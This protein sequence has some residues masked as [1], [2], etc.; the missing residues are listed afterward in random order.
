MYLDLKFDRKLKLVTNRLL[1]SNE[2]HIGSG[3]KLAPVFLKGARPTPWVF[4]SHDVRKKY[5]WFWNRVCTQEFNLIPSHCRF[6][7]WKV[8]I[9]PNNVKELFKCYDILKI[10]DL[11]SKIGA[12]VRQYTYGPWAGFVYADT[13]EEGRKYYKIV[14]EAMP[15]KVEVILKRGCTE[16]ERIQDSDYWDV[17]G[18]KDLELEQRLQDLFAF[19]ERFFR[20]A[21]WLK[22]EIKE[23]WIRRA[24]EIGDPYAREMAEKLSNDPDI[25][26]KL[27]VLSVPYHDETKDVGIYRPEEKKKEE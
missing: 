8:V 14:R 20:Q 15:K 26:K 9:K 12:D 1:A 7:C 27:V 4:I 3:G 25:W 2:F 5:C 16:M 11:P 6:S 22:N 13:L 21:R 19:D 18:E 17:M 10:L 24:I 23:D